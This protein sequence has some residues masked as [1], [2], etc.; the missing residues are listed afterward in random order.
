MALLDFLK[1]KPVAPMP[2]YSEPSYVPQQGSIPVEQVMIMR[3]QGASNPQ[4]IQ[5]LQK[6]YS[7]Q[8][9]ADALA[10]SE[11]RMAGEPYPSAPEFIPQAQPQMSNQN[12][13]E[14]VELQI[15]EK[16]K[17][18]ADELKPLS[19]WKDSVESRLS[20]MNNDINAVKS[21]VEKI[22]KAV[23]G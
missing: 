14:E 23:F 8:A 3:Q 11:A 16:W 15:N 21:E 6:N 9:I 18:L 10:Q 13:T 20:Q 7:S 19:E 22:H 1:K 5:T 2:G 12:V 4:I 17:A